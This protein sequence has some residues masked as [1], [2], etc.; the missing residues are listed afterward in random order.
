M[1]TLSIPSTVGGWQTYFQ[2]NIRG[3]LRD[4]VK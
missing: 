4:V 2:I 1:L 3:H